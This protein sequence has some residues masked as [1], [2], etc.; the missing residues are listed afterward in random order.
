VIRLPIDALFVALFGLLAMSC[1]GDD[2]TGNPVLPGQPT[3]AAKAG[4]VAVKT[5]PGSCQVDVTGDV[6]VSFKGQG[7]QS[8]VGSDYWLSDD[9]LRTAL[10]AVANISN[11]GSDA[12][13]KKSVDEAMKKDPRLFLLILNCISGSGDSKDTISMLPSGDSKYADVPFK[14]GSYTIKSGSHLTSAEKPGDFS[15]LM[16]LSKVSYLVSQDGKL[17]ITKF[18]KSGI[19]GTFTFGGEQGFADQGAKPKKISVSG[20]FDFPCTSGGNCNK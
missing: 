7:G 14:P 20:K 18:D 13:K 16:S 19:A 9:D 17:N 11:K 15:A 10:S 1:G 3:S 4:D 5:G 2:S 8:A 12:E 6:T